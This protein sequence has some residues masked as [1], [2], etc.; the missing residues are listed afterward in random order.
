MARRETNE[1]RKQKFMKGDRVAIEVRGASAISYEPHIIKGVRRGIV[2]L[3]DNDDFVFDAATGERTRCEPSPFGFSFQIVPK[4][5]VPM[6]EW[7][8]RCKD[9][10]ID[11]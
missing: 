3:E 4:A 2:Y 11:P 1:A 8:R 9:F 7:K 6:A 5:E 10:G